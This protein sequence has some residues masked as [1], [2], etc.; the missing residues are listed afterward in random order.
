M[1][2]SPHLAAVWA[3]VDFIKDV[4]YPKRFTYPGIVSNDGSCVFLSA[5]FKGINRCGVCV[6]YG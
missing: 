2:S 4:L 1:L 5:A 3:E 6:V